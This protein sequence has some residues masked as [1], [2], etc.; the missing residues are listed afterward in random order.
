MLHTKKVFAIVL[1]MLLLFT[2]YVLMFVNNR[3]S[4]KEGKW[5]AHSHQVGSVI[6]DLRTQRKS[7]ILYTYQAATQYGDKA[8]INMV[9]AADSAE[10]LLKQLKVLVSDNLGMTQ[11]VEKNLEHHLMNDLD[12]AR[13]VLKEV[14][15]PTNSLDRK[16]FFLKELDTTM[17]INAVPQL[18]NQLGGREESLLASRKDKL[19]ELTKNIDNVIW[20]SLLAALIFTIIAASIFNKEIKERK[21]A[22]YKSTLY[23]SKLET[24]VAELETAN[25]EITTLKN[26]EKFSSTGRMA[27][28]I[29]HEIRNPL[30]N[31]NLANEQIKDL[32]PEM[33]EAKMLCNMVDRNSIRINELISNLLN[34]TRFM[35]I[36]MGDVE[37]NAVIDEALELAKDRINLLDIK[38]LKDYK[39]DFCSLKGDA[40]K[41]KIAILNII[42]N[43]IEA[44]PDH[45]GV[46]KITTF[47][48][49]AGRCCVKISDNGKGMSEDV[50]QKLFDPFFTTKEKGNGLGMTNTQNVII[51]HKGELN[52]KSKPSV[53]TEFEIIL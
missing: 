39:T 43:A 36:N 32:L 50:V 1:T 47:E 42:V 13:T 46:L 40:D 30:T 44:M 17:Q 5:I 6:S 27:R 2:S 28:T 20:G 34:A 22:I 23:K 14:I 41:L 3:Q 51:A 8:A 25:R 26:L 12:V 33:E 45:E 4:K 21:K 53:G 7:A 11:I 18:L 48:D 49:L 31:I 10:V 16:F 9:K 24:Q 29:A 15:S 38:I 37:I 35:E 52:V 19:F